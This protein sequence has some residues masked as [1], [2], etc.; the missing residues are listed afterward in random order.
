MTT[1]LCLFRVYKTGTTKSFRSIHNV[2]DRGVLQAMW[3]E[4]AGKVGHR[5]AANHDCLKTLYVEYALHHVHKK[6]TIFLTI[7]LK[8]A[9]EYPSSVAYSINDLYL[10]MWRKNCPLHLMY[11]CTHYLVTLSKSKL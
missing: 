5:D 10:T 1:S 7:T 4:L 3:E 9:K 2:V 8:V 11:V 6:L